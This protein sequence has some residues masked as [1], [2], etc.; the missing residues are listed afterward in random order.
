MKKILV[1]GSAGFIGS[2]L[3]IQTS[4]ERGD[5]V[6]G[7]DNLNDYYDVGLKEARLVMNH[8]FIHYKID[9]ANRDELQSVFGRIIWKAWVN[10]AFEQVLGTL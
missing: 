1:T 6:I 9:I 4:Q 2:A 8:L 10:L 3:A 7:V 5:Y